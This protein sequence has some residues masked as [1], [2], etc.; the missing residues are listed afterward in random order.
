MRTAYPIKGTENGE[1]MK[2]II[3]VGK[4][5]CF[6][7]TGYLPKEFAKFCR[8]K[9]NACKQNKM[10]T[11]NGFASFMLTP[12]LKDYL[13]EFAEKNKIE[14][15]KTK[16]EIDTHKNLRKLIKYFE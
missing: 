13:E 15:V 16:E 10:A 14:I 1:I 12:Y 9:E 2:N 11:S 6:M 8:T 3:V 4:M 5:F 7:R